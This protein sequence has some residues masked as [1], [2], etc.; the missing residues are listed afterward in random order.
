MCV[1]ER[2]L[3]GQL[4][5]GQMGDLEDLQRAVCGPGCDS[6]GGVL[7]WVAHIATVHAATWAL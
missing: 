6:Q 3:L 2:D 5:P 1:W 7:F 4:D